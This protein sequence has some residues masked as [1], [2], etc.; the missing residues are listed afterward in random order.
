LYDLK[1][2]GPSSLDVVANSA[3]L[4]WLFR[5][6]SRLKILS[7][8]SFYAANLTRAQGEQ[9]LARAEEIQASPKQEPPIEEARSGG[10]AGAEI[11]YALL[12]VFVM[13]QAK[14][15]LDGLWI[16][17]LGNLKF[18][19]RAQALARLLGLYRVRFSFVSPAA[20]SMPYDL[21]D[22]LRAAGLEVEETND[23][24]ATLQKADILYLSPIDPALVEKRIYDKTKDFYQLSPAVL[25][26]A[27]DG[28]LISGDWDD[29][30]EHLEG[31]RMLMNESYSALHAALKEFN[32]SE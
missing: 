24:S 6:K 21:S 28:L 1:G 11:E 3:K 31:A 13:R 7:N 15:R 18:S 12:T 14:G 9:I 30:P 22:D 23:L 2:L 26:G 8:N 5:I 29:L 27:K 25:S 19:P 16:A 4:V 10:R 17:L 20:L 32:L